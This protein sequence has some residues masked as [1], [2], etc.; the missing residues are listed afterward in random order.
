MNEKNIKNI[1]AEITPEIQEAVD[2]QVRR[3][4]ELANHFTHI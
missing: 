1:M 2:L 4:I 3:M